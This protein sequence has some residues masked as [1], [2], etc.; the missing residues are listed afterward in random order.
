MTAR[1][2]SGS[3]EQI[4]GASAML[5]SAVVGGA[6]LG[7]PKPF[8]RGTTKPA[9]V[10][11]ALGLLV[12][13]ATS[14]NAG[15]SFDCG[16]AATPVERA[17]CADPAIADLDGQVAAAYKAARQSLAAEPK[18]LAELAAAQRSFIAERNSAFGQPG[19]S[20]AELL[21][22][23][24]AELRQSRPIPAAA[25]WQRT[26]SAENSRS[27]VAKCWMGRSIQDPVSMPSA[28][29]QRML[30]GSRFR[31]ATAPRQCSPARVNGSRPRAMM[32]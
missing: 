32:V 8:R 5:A 7:A 9:I 6:I 28:C 15:A 22:K 24:L 19:F 4:A 29:R 25:G 31:A 30:S 26:R 21:A 18:R 14:A 3:S 1:T 10:I 27:I 17:I 2:R 12:L 16:K 13:T 20:L 23:R 11:R